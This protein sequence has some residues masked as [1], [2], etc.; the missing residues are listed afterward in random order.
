MELVNYKNRCAINSSREDGNKIDMKKF[1][2][3]KIYRHM[4]I[5]LLVNLVSHGFL[6]LLTGTFWDDWAY[7]YHETDQLW[8]QHLELGQPLRIFLIETVWQLPDY[9]YRMVVFLLYLLTS[10]LFYFILNNCRYVDR[11]QALMISALYVAV[12]VNTARLI[13]CCIEYI[14]ALSCFLTAFY[15]FMFYIGWGKRKHGLRVVIHVLFLFSFSMNSNLVFYS[16]ALFY[17]AVVEY[18]RSNSGRQFFK[19]LIRYFDFVFTPL[20]FFILKKLFFAPYGRYE[21]YNQ[22][23]M[24]KIF[25]AILLTV[26]G[27]VPQTI[28]IAKQY[29]EWIPACARLLFIVGGGTLIVICSEKIVYK[30]NMRRLTISSGLRLSN[31]LFNE[32]RG[33]MIKLTVGITILGIGMFPYIAVRQSDILQVAGV[34]GRDSILLPFGVSICLCALICLLF[35]TKKLRVISVILVIICGALSLNY[36]YL[37][38]QRVA[39]WQ[40]ALIYRMAENN[41]IRNHSN[42]L[43][44]TSESADSLYGLRFYSINGV[45]SKAFGNKSRLFMFGYED[46]QY[47]QP[48][49][50]RNLL[51]KKGYLT[52]DYDFEDTE[53]DGVIVYNCP[54]TLSEVLQLKVKEIFS[55]QEFESVIRTYG[56]LEY[57]PVNSED[58]INSGRWYSSG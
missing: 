37:N 24:G 18:I 12:P 30:T 3:N 27:L 2:E 39:Y 28:L 23:N 50:R 46:L 20:F 19:R 51:R 36:S 21:G 53:L 58:E 48:G 35:I 57:Y 10:V 52:D 32:I 34:D 44:L 13:L 7:I 5:L 33:Y 16:I 31:S 9:R 45:A 26:K 15:L 11:E 40:E 4:V 54:F 29:I 43:F 38:Y 49:E 1:L 22:L 47:L 41:E 25:N 56:I 17:I 6:I 8:E 55:R 42:F 14:F